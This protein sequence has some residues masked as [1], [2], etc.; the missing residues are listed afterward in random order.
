VVS[1]LL[2]RCLAAD[3]QNPHLR[4]REVLVD[5]SST[6]DLDACSRGQVTGLL[7]HDPRV[8]NEAAL[9]GAHNLDL[10]PLP[11]RTN[12]LSIVKAHEFPP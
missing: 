9:G 3:F 12:H 1:T 5:S 4:T 10:R 11:L 2:W 7:R 6:A 8:E